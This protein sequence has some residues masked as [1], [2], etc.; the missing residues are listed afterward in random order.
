MRIVIICSVR[1]GTPNEVYDYVS[2]LE[3]QGHSVYFPPRDT[4]QKSS[5]GVDIGRRMRWAIQ[6]ADEVH[7]H[8]SPQSQGIHFDM[9]MA[10]AL[11]KRWKL[12][13]QPI[14]SSD[15]SY[16]KVIKCTQGAPPREVIR[17]ESTNSLP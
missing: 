9:G 6:K 3:K 8:Y 15:K 12:V 7:I 17:N 16:I 14:D 13:N 2:S 11:K 5:T 4:P 10:F 1:N